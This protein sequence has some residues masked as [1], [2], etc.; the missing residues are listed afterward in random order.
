MR[1]PL[2]QALILTGLLVGCSAKQTPPVTYDPPTARAK[3]VAA[4]PSGWTAIKTDWQQ[5]S[6]TTSFFND[7][8]TE[9]F[10]LVGP[11][12]R[13]GYSESKGEK[14][15]EDIFKESIFVWIV[16]GDFSPTF[17]KVPPG[18]R[19][20]IEN[21]FSSRGVRVYANVE[22]Y[23]SDTNRWQQIAIQQPTPRI[24]SWKLWNEDIAAALNK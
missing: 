6:D 15:R 14:H 12:S 11:Q 8:R 20:G 3:V 18:Y 2:R 17:P 16:T 4:L 21:I 7:P 23:I 10:M 19:M 1:L 9:A 13:Y 22:N 24:I 5:Q